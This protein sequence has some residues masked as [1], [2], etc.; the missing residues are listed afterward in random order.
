MKSWRHYN[1]LKWKQ[2]IVRNSRLYLPFASSLFVSF[3]YICIY[4]VALR[5]RSASHSIFLFLFKKFCHLDENIYS[6]ASLILMFSYR[7]QY[8]H[9]SISCAGKSNNTA[10]RRNSKGFKVG[11]SAN[12]DKKSI[13]EIK[14]VKKWFSCVDGIFV[15]ISVHIVCCSSHLLDEI[16]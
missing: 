12:N 11:E 7:S 10:K 15:H 3:S 16:I 5:L 6:L 9:N 8:I 2:K 14:L 13:Y 4:F 1:A